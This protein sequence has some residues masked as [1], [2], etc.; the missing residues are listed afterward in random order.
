MVRTNNGMS[1]H[2]VEIRIPF[3]KFMFVSPSIVQKEMIC[4]W[5]VSCRSIECQTT[6][7]IIRKTISI[8]EKAMFTFYI[9]YFLSM[10]NQTEESESTISQKIWSTKIRG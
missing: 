7:T 5:I 10:F 4:N 2:Y 9:S 6:K 3:Y 1:I 8:T